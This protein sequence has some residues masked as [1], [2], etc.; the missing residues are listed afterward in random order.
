MNSA[1][2]LNTPTGEN[3]RE[4]SLLPHNKEEDKTIP[5]SS[6]NNKEQP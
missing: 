3:Y 6:H 5:E 4:Q 2:A 1:A